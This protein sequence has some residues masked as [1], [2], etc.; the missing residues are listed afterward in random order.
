MVKPPDINCAPREKL[1]FLKHVESVLLQILRHPEALVTDESSLRDFSINDSDDAIGLGKGCSTFLF[2]RKF[3][4][5]NAFE[6]LR[7]ES[8]WQEEIYEAR[9]V[10][11]RKMTTRKILRHTGVDITPVFDKHFPVILQYIAAN[12][13]LEKRSKLAQIGSES[14]GNPDS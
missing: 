11:F 12:M 10:P 9:A 2:R 13:P 7:D 4:R 5:G 14:T 1:R 3:Y 6:G 8:N